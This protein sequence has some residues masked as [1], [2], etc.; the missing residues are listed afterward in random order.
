V[1]DVSKVRVGMGLLLYKGQQIVA[2]AVV[3]D[4]GAGQ[5]AARVTSVQAP[6]ADSAAP[7]VTLE[8][9]DVVHFSDHAEAITPGMHGKPFAALARK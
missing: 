4:L 2:Q 6:G 9:D 7:S 3:E 5:V 8:A 1:A